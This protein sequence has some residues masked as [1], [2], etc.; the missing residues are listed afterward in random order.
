MIQTF[1]RSK[2]MVPPP[3][4]HE[5]K[6]PFPTRALQVHGGIVEEY[7]IPDESK[8]T[9]LDQLYI[10]DP[11]P[12]LDEE[13]YDLHEGKRFRVRDFRVTWEN[14]HNFLVSPYYP[15]SGGTVV[16]WVSLEFGE[17]D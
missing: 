14:G 3:E 4:R 16:D 9:V 6:E 13:L 17:G 5:E 10:F 7:I 1:A 11:V 2:T 15:S 8:E 12:S